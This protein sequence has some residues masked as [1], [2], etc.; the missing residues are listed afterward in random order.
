MDQFIAEARS[1]AE[2][3]PDNPF[4]INLHADRY[5]YL[6]AFCAAL[7]AGQCTLMPPNRQAATLES[8]SESYPG[9]YVLGQGGEETLPCVSADDASVPEIPDQQLAAIAFTSGSTGTPRPNRK[10][11]RTF[12]AGTR[13]NA[14]M[15]LDDA[16]SCV[17]MLATVPPQHMWGMETSILL[18][19][20]AAVAISD[21]TPFYP[22]DIADALDA[23][24]EPKVLVSSPIHLEA[25]MKSGVRTRSISKILTATAP[26]SRELAAALEA[27]LGTRVQDVF[28]C[29]ESGILATRR[30]ALDEEWRYSTI[31][32]LTMTGEGVVISAEHLP[33]D[34]LLPD[35]I[36]LTAKD[37]FRWVGRQQDMVNIAGKRGSLADMNLRLREIP[38]IVDG[39][40]FEPDTGTGRLAALVTAP[41]LNV[42]D[43]LGALRSRIDPVFLP[44]PVI[45]VSELPRL[46][47]GKIRIDAVRALFAEL[48]SANQRD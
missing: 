7:L 5:L 11:W 35:I 43:I 47:T 29:S 48:N 42:S 16:T 32:T 31:F 40:I 8:L 38:G 44:R 28:G 27:S 3:L 45:R 33:E 22:Q 36:E 12:C 34:V 10:Y 18:P 30:T 2:K 9:T 17:N 25:L 6:R 13:S 19:L 26:L 4:V 21:V 23:L 14:T 15:V 1:L 20:F 41:D 24:P 46:E 37:R 39:V